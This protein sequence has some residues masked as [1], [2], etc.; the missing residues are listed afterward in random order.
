MPLLRLS[1][2]EYT[3]IKLMIEHGVLI[4]I[5]SQELPRGGFIKIAC[6]DGDATPEMINHFHYGPCVE[7]NGST[8]CTHLVPITGG[9]GAMPGVSPMHSLV[10]KNV[11]WGNADTRV[12][13]D[14]E[15]ALSVKRSAHG[16][17]VPNVALIPHAPCGMANLKN[18]SVWENFYLTILAKGMIRKEF[19]HTFESVK[20]MPHINFLGYP[21]AE[22]P[23]GSFRTYLLRSK[24]FKELCAEQ[25]IVF[26]FSH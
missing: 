11:A 10:Y 24:K 21:E 6:P 23:K 13:S 2:T 14:M 9:P 8:V 16:N 4:P 26:C 5:D 25:G 22:S 18:L 15:L 1:R 19:P 20:I 17:R 3:A 7:A 12:Y